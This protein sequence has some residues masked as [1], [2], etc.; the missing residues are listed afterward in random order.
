M[1]ALAEILLVYDRFPCQICEGQTSHGDGCAW[2]A[3]KNWEADAINMIRRI[4][5]GE[6]G[7]QLP[8]SKDDLPA[9]IRERQKAGPA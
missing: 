9:E 3:I 4:R 7:D 6:I 2:H 5:A 8:D 1:D